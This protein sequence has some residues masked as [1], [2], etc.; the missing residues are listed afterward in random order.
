MSHSDR[1]RNNLKAGIFVLLGLVLAFVVIV[2]VG[3]A[4]RFLSARNSYLLRFGIGLGVDGVVAGSPVKIGGLAAG[5]VTAVAPELEGDRV[6]GAV[7]TV[8]IDRSMA[9]YSNATIERVAPLLGGTAAIHIDNVGGADGGRRLE[10]G[11]LMEVR[12]G[13]AGGG[14][15]RLVG[16]QNAQRITEI[17]ANL[18]ATLAA[19]GR[20]YDASLGP[21]I[22]QLG[23]A[24]ADARE[25]VA[26]VKAD[27]PQWRERIDSTL[28]N[29]DEAS[30]RLPPTLDDAKALV[31]DL[32]SGTAKIVS[33]V[34]D[35]RASIDQIIGN[36]RASSDDL[37]EILRRA[38]AELVDRLEGLFD[39]ADRG[40]AAF[41]EVAERIRA[42]ID[43]I[44]P[45]LE[46]AL[47]DARLMAGQ[48]KL[49][50]IEVRRSPWR[51][52]YRPTE[53]E[54]ENELLFDAAR[55]FA[56][57]ASDLRSSVETIDRVLS[58]DPTFFAS[59]PEQAQRVRDL[60]T[61]SLERYEQAQNRLFT[62]IVDGEKKLKK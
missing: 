40:L 26:A 55:S 17:L 62:I 19:I 13:G 25:V 11:D 50:A 36:V 47:A 44:A 49:A 34:D 43:L 3:D 52:L 61:G 22:R 54:L 10:D 31:G 46:S 28:R 32:R 48:L 38:R 1:S 24:L 45:D 42:E 41:T 21:G 37:R 27:Y 39:Q 16:E 53:S 15:R 2:L 12:G 57:V 7:V 23:D 14:L 20:D 18:D 29:V 51:L 4:S 58:R 59:Q 35:N 60:L 33:M 6:V 9:L 5:R 8:E 30:A 56:L